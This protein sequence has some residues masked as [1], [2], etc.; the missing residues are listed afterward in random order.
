MKNNALEGMRGIAAFGVLMAHL[1]LSLFP[2]LSTYQAPSSQIPQFYEFESFLM[3]PPIMALINGSFGV[4]VF[5]VLSGYVLT[6][7]FFKT[8]DVSILQSSAV[9]RYPRLILPAS[10]SVLFAWG[11]LT[12]G[13]M[14]NDKIPLLGGAGWPYD[15]YTS[16]ASFFRAL[17]DAYIG[18]PI[19]GNVSLNNPLW[20]IQIELF[21]SLFLFAAYA[22]FGTR[23]LILTF[24]FFAFLLIL[25]KPGDVSQVHYYAM[26]GGSILNVIEPWLK[27]MPLAAT[28]LFLFGWALGGFDYSHYYSILQVA[29]LPA[30]PAPL[31]NLAGQ[32]KIVFMSIGAI[33]LIGGVLG[34]GLVSRMLNSKVPLF[35]GRIS[36][37]S[38]L[39]HWP[40]ICSLGFG[41]QH[42]FFVTL[43]LSHLTSS[44]LTCVITIPTIF[45]ISIF[46]T[47]AVDAP[48]VKLA[49]IFSDFYWRR[50]SKQKNVEADLHVPCPEFSSSK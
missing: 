22:L 47:S 34:S 50:G 25:I 28:A 49:N 1:L 9:K 45:A 24:L 30:L 11:L 27:R 16:P 31:P 17:Y 13:L 48:S 3:L 43:G 2:Y 33:L 42:L 46:F 32:E 36:Y 39:L 5:F 23:N 8:N 14:N 15:Q 10:I 12:L 20:T 7:K 19:F 40:I 41:L 37:A 29:A 26:F 4:S 38:Y 6:K 35:L 21:G 18:A 44:L